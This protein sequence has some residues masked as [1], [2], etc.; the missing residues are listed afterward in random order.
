MRDYIT[1]HTVDDA[2]T[3]AAKNLE[4]Q[5]SAHGLKLIKF[6]YISTGNWHRNTHYKVNCILEAFSYGATEV[7]C[8]DADSQILQNPDPVFNEIAKQPKNIAFQFEKINNRF[9]ASGGVYWFRR[10]DD[11][12]A[13]LETWIKLCKTIQNKP[14]DT[15]LESFVDFDK[16]LCLP[17]TVNNYKNKSK[18]TVI[19][20]ERLSQRKGTWKQ[21]YAPIRY[22]ADG[23]IVLLRKN[24]EAEKWLDSQY[25][26]SGTNRWYQKGRSIFDTFDKVTE[27][28]NIVGKGPSLDKIQS[29]HLAGHDT[30]C[31]NDS[32]KIIEELETPCRL[33]CVTQDCEALKGYKPKCPIFCLTKCAYI[34]PDS[35][36]YSE[37]ELDITPNTLSAVIAIRIAKRLGAT[38]VNL[39]AFDSAKGITDY[40]KSLGYS[41]SLVARPARFLEH[42][43]VIQQELQN[44]KLAYQLVP[45]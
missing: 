3:N 6:P 12:I 45:L 22:L 11:V 10:S 1:C 25:V 35:Y 9:V 36:N 38:S 32:V 29:R 30:F 5:L 16:V 33:F 14:E 8:M 41:P 19:G 23:S 43:K 26:R 39:F 2:Y 40:A 15:V 4:T 42:W 17:A 7:V 28:I 37:K 13:L 24:A 34:H 20:H 21:I 31:L 27:T 44:A 18:D